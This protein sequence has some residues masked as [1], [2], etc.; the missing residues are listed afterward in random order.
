[1]TAVTW[2]DLNG[3]GGLDLS[4]RTI[5]RTRVRRSHTTNL[6][7]DIAVAGVTEYAEITGVPVASPIQIN[8]SDPVRAIQEMA[9]QLQLSQADVCQACGVS[10]RSFK[11]WKRGTKPQSGSFAQ[12]WNVVMVINHL[13]QT[14][15]DLVAWLHSSPER[16]TRFISGDATGVMAESSQEILTESGVV[17]ARLFSEVEETE[18]GP[19][20][21]RVPLTVTQ[22][23]V[24][25]QALNRE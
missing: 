15:D 12:L 17:E 4:K 22:R 20:A 23:R 9:V 19:S 18:S 8:T 10:A 14:R 6:V 25:R 24:R 11:R 3:T 7:L 21:P 1:M 5:N 13:A 2:A 16:L